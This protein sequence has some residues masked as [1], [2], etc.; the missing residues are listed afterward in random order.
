MPIR[1]AYALCIL[2]SK[3]FVFA[4]S[5]NITECSLFN[6]YLASHAGT[7]NQ[8]KNLKRKVLKCHANIYF[9]QRCSTDCKRYE[10]CVIEATYT[11]SEHEIRIAF[12]RQQWFRERACMLTFIRTLSSYNRE[13]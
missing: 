3:S 1:T 13:R 8:Y 4:C 12:P 7:I 10:Y 5:T 2:G 11:H 6:Q 9:N